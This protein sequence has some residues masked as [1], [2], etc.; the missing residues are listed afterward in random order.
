[1]AVMKLQKVQFYHKLLNVISEKYSIIWNQSQKRLSCLANNAIVALMTVRL[2]SLT[3]VNGD[4]VNTCLQ[5]FYGN[6]IDFQSK[7]GK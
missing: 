6:R 3:N 7:I 4:K 1:M 2:E 5:D